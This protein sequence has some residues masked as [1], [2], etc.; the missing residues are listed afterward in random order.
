[1]IFKTIISILLFFSS[2][3]NCNSIN[4]NTLNKSQ[5]NDKVIKV[6][7][8]YVSLFISTF[9][10]INCDDFDHFFGKKKREKLITDTIEIRRIVNYLK[11]QERNDTVN[12]ID[13]RLKIILYKSNQK[14][15]DTICGSSVVIQRNEINQLINKDFQNYL[16]NLTK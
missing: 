13:T 2:L 8:V 9:S 16:R 3:F 6:K 10:D 12:S 15:N 14:E 11:N 5:A 1:M 4:E 7:L